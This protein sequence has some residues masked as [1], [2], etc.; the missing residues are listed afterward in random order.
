MP[1]RFILSIQYH[2]TSRRRDDDN[3][4]YGAQARPRRASTPISTSRCRRQ[5]CRAD[6]TMHFSRHAAYFLALQECGRPRVSIREMASIYG[7]FSRCR[8]RWLSFRHYST[9]FFRALSCHIPRS[10]RATTAPTHA[11][12]AAVGPLHWGRDSLL[13]F[14]ATPRSGDAAAC[15][16]AAAPPYMGRD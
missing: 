10:A 13:R 12:R 5:G 1:L 16:T 14:A 9:I 3:T 11:R 8:A 7:E 15:S 4:A 2:G 6:A